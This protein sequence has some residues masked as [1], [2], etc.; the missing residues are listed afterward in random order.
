MKMSFGNGI[1]FKSN[2]EAGLQYGPEYGSIIAE[3]TEEIE[4][5]ELIGWTT[6]DGRI[7]YGSET[8][9]IEELYALNTGV[10]ENVYPTKTKETDASIPAFGSTGTVTLA[11][12]VKVAKPKA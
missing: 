11:P 7:T 8:V 12:A 6:G 10:L 2:P 5:A 4:G 3:L 9:S 1:G